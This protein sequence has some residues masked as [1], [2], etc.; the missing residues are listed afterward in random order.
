MRSVCHAHGRQAAA[1][2]PMREAFSDVFVRARSTI[3]IRIAALVF[4]EF[5]APAVDGRAERTLARSHVA[6][7]ATP[8]TAERI[9][10]TISMS[11]LT[12]RHVGRL[13]RAG[14]GRESLWSGTHPL[15]P[16]SRFAHTPGGRARTVADVD[17]GC[18]G[19]ECRGE[20][21]RRDVNPLTFLLRVR[22]R[23]DLRRHGRPRYRHTVRD[24]GDA[25]RRRLADR[26]V[27]S[28][29]PRRE[30]CH[31]SRRPPSF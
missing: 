7:S 4:R 13:R 18:A 19:I 24:S 20:T 21:G 6:P 1:T 5:A 31:D 25:R 8:D 27:I 26:E 16:A 9:A 10:V 3:R 14:L 2:Q 15:T 11:A 23:G 12:T 17:V 22:E 30:S 28:P 29:R